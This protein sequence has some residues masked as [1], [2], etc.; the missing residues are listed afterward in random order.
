MPVGRAESDLAMPGIGGPIEEI[1]AKGRVF[2]SASDS[3]AP[4][5]TGGFEVAIESN[6][7]GSARKLLSRIPWS[8]EG[9]AVDVQHDRGD[10]EFLEELAAEK[11]WYPISI[12]FVSGHVY[13]G[14]GSITGKAEFGHQKSTASF[15]LG[16]PA[17]A[18]K[19]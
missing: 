17:N 3:D 5:I 10:L 8:L 4:F 11:D 12:K 18:E 7:D 1:S 16:G 13:S 15:G 6:G 2:T 14:K 19:Q 9:V